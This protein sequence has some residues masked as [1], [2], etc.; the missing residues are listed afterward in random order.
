MEVAF[1]IPNG[2]AVPDPPPQPHP[3]DFYWICGLPRFESFISWTN[4]QVT[5]LIL[6]P[7]YT[8]TP[9]STQFNVVDFPPPGS[10]QASLLDPYMQNRNPGMI[11]VGQDV[12]SSNKLAVTM[13]PGV[14][15]ERM[16]W[17]RGGVGAP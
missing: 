9:G 5:V 2:A 14:V 16:H 6:T 3:L 11:F 13:S 1:N 4:R 15:V 7:G 12:G 8:S 17:L 10:D